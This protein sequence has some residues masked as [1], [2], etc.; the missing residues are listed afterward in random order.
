[1]I[2]DRNGPMLR[3]VHEGEGDR[4]SRNRAAAAADELYA[5]LDGGLVIYLCDFPEA[6]PY[7]ST[8]GSQRS[9]T[10]AFSSEVERIIF[11]G[12]GVD[13]LRG[14]GGIG[15]GAGVW[16]RRRLGAGVGRRI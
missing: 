7:W 2:P 11:G 1:M 13:S 6:G 10:S 3:S 16:V 15:G 9:W 4:V 14:L 12:E 8:G 5:V